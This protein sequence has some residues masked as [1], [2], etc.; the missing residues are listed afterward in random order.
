MNVLE[1]KNLTKRFGGLTAVNDVSFTI[2]QHGIKGLIGPNGA[3]KTTIFNLITGVYKVSSGDIAFK[4]KPIQNI[5]PFK[6][7]AGGITRTFQNIR[8]FKKLTTYEN[9]LTACHL[10]AQYS[11]AESILFG[12]LPS[13]IKSNAAQANLY[14]RVGRQRTCCLQAISSQEVTTAYGSNAG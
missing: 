7:A 9:I 12:F 10:S 11:L 5:Q 13:G 2:K 4:G 6:I 8:L 3:G 1:V 14:D